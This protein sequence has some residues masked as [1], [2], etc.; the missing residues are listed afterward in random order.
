MAGAAAGGRR[1]EE[2]QRDL[3]RIN[4]LLSSFN[5]QCAPQ[6]PKNTSM[7]SAVQSFAPAMPFLMQFGRGCVAVCAPQAPTILT[8]HTATQI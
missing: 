6:A 8:A 1:S 3:V 7:Q 2:E 5:T 4:W